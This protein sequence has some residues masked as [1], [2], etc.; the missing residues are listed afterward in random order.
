[1]GLASLRGGEIV[2]GWLA[3]EAEKSRVGGEGKMFSCGAVVMRA[4]GGEREKF[5]GGLGLDEAE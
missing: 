3:A 4:R 2:P 5:A 1:M